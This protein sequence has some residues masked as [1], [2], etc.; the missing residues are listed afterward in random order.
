MVG[1]GGGSLEDFW[2]FNEEVVVWSIFVFELLVVFVVGY[3]VD[4]IFFDLVVD[5]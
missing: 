1:W 5:V 4:V 3:E 2:C